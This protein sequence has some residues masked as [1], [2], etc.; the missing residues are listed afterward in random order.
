MAEAVLRH[1]LEQ[2]G[3]SDRVEVDSAGT[4]NWHTG[5]PPHH[6]TR[7]ILEQEQISWEG[8]VARQIRLSDLTTFDYIL[9]MDEENLRSV[10]RIGKAT[11]IVAPLLSFAP[12]LG[13]L[14]G[15]LEVPDPY[16]N[17]K[18]TEVYK[19]VDAACDGFIAHLNL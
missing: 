3:L 8:I 11:G 15:I 13:I 19:L 12:H 10:L 5:D 7:T 17:N 16:Y 6:G 1:K 18:F 4:G 9:T 2:A 14:E